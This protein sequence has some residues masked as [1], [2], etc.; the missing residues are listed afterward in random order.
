MSK[1]EAFML[2]LLGTAL[3]FFICMGI[4]RPVGRSESFSI[5]RESGTL[6]DSKNRLTY[7]TDKQPTERVYKALAKVTT[8][9]PEVLFIQNRD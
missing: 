2:T 1:K 8:M 6:V 3:G 5:L 4:Y 7:Y 9:Y